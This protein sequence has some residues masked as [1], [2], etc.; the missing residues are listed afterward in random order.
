M[1]RTALFC[2]VIAACGPAAAQPYGRYQVTAAPGAAGE[3][4]T[5]VM[6]DT[7]TGQSWVLVQTPGPPVQWAPLRFW[8][9]GNPPVLSPLPPSAADVG[10]RSSG[11]DA[12]RAR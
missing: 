9:P 6:L 7:A 1:L 8:A 10:S 11:G 2:A 4:P 3:P 5:V 12:A